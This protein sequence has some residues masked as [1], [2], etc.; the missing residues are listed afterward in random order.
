[1]VQLLGLVW[2]SITWITSSKSSPRVTPPP[3]GQKKNIHSFCL[4]VWVLDLYFSF[5]SKLIG[6]RGPTVQKEKNNLLNV[7]FVLGR[8]CEKTSHESFPTA[9]SWWETRLIGNICRIVNICEWQASNWTHWAVFLCFYLCIFLGYWQKKTAAVCFSS[10]WCGQRLFVFFFPRSM[11]LTSLVAP[12]GYRESWWDQMLKQLLLLVLL[13]SWGGRGQRRLRPPAGRLHLAV[14]PQWRPLQFFL[15]LL[16][17]DN[18]AGLIQSGRDAKR[19]SGSGK[20][21]LRAKSWPSL[22][23]RLEWKSCRCEVKGLH[24]STAVAVA[25]R[26]SGPGERCCL[27]RALDFQ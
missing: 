3:P 20:K 18:L 27:Q 21:R 17:P 9:G 25:R 15:E 12:S 26:S 16:R 5:E 11:S 1:M 4:K 14:D 8:K 24:L 2:V 19:V 10:R 13:C 22:L 6:P 7:W 23:H